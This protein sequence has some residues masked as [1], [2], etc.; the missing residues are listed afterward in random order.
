MKSFSQKLK[1]ARARFGL[2]QKQLGDLVGVSQRS[3]AAYET[4]ATRPRGRLLGRLAAALQ[5]SVDYL[6]DDAITD[7]QQGIEKDPCVEQTRQRLGNEAA[8]EI[9][10]LLEQ[11]IAF[12]AGGKLDQEAKDAFFEAVMRAYLSCKEEA[13]RKYG[14]AGKS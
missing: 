11:N 9:N 4:T 12:F 13:K 7:P 14:P 8:R 10:Q 2:S 1:E 5:V 3:I 6:L